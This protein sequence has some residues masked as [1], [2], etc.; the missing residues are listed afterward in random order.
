MQECI[1]NK[2]SYFIQM[3][4]IADANDGLTNRVF[5]QPPILYTVKELGF[6]WFMQISGRTAAQAVDSPKSYEV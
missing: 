2:M 5:G 6:K 3:F 1:F 4:I